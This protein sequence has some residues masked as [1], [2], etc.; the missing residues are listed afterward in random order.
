MG[1]QMNLGNKLEPE[2]WKPSE[3]SIAS[4]CPSLCHS[5]VLVATCFP[6]FPIYIKGN[7]KT[8]SKPS[9]LKR[10]ISFLFPIPNSQEGISIGRKFYWN[11]SLDKMKGWKQAGS[12]CN[13]MHENQGKKLMEKKRDETVNSKTHNIY[14]CFSFIN[15]FLFSAINCSQ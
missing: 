13:N 4:L 8:C 3:L 14:K 2:T 10:L 12:H 9:H 1:K 7:V 11:Q 15:V 5:F 6:W